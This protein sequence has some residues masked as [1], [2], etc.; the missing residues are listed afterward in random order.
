MLD[1]VCNSTSSMNSR[2]IWIIIAALMFTKL[3]V[4]NTYVFLGWVRN[5]TSSMRYHAE[6]ATPQYWFEINVTFLSFSVE[7]ATLRRPWAFPIWMIITV[8]ALHHNRV[9]SNCQN[10]SEARD[11][12]NRD[13]DS[14]LSCFVPESIDTRNPNGHGL[15]PSTHLL[16]KSYIW[17]LIRVHLN[18]LEA[19]RILCNNS[20]LHV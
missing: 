18:N 10:L 15:A 16:G 6:K 11:P 3:P 7:F 17:I 20:Q 14:L 2:R 5:T 12:D 19:I 8:H 9:L 4:C 1:W 13:T